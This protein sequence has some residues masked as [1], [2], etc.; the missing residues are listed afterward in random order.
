MVDIAPDP[1]VLVCNVPASDH[2]WVYLAIH[3]SPI[4]GADLTWT[5]TMGYPAASEPQVEFKRSAVAL[6]KGAQ[7]LDW[8]AG[9]YTRL[10]LPAQVSPSQIAQIIIGVMTQVQ[11]VAADEEVEITLEYISQ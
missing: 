11:H 4:T 6:P 2:G 5:L 10:N 7:V 3:L 8:A 1:T 9:V